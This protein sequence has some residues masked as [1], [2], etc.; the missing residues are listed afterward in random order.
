MSWDLCWQSLCFSYHHCLSECILFTDDSGYF[1]DTENQLCG[2]KITEL[3]SLVYKKVQQRKSH[4][5][6]FRNWVKLEIAMTAVKTLFN[7]LLLIVIT[8]VI[9]TLKNDE[10]QFNLDC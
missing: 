9:R 6:Y 4:L 8:A 5:K 2:N 3:H 10:G 7:I 1:L